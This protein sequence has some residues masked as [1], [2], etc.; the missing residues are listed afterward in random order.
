MDNL[1]ENYSVLFTRITRME[2]IRHLNVKIKITLVVLFVISTVFLVF[3]G[4]TLPGKYFVSIPLFTTIYWLLLG[5]Q[6]IVIRRKNTQFICFTSLVQILTL[7]ISLLL[8]IGLVLL[9]LVL[10]EH[11]H[12]DLYADYGYILPVFGIMEF[13]Y[14]VTATLSSLYAFELYKK[15]KQDQDLETKGIYIIRNPYGSIYSNQ[16]SFL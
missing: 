2:R 7:L 12:I 8:Y 10:L 16:P 14:L 15:Y 6:W 11:K 4:L 13:V 9:F 5:F 3:C 1:L